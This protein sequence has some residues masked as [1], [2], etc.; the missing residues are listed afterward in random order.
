MESSRAVPLPLRGASPQ[1]RVRQDLICGLVG[2]GAV[3]APGRIGVRAPPAP[4]WAAPRHY[5]L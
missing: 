2:G 1:E 3:P 4:D 5:Q